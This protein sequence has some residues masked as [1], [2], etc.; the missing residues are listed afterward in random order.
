MESLRYAQETDASHFEF[1]KT[2]DT[3]GMI[4]AYSPLGPKD[5]VSPETVDGVTVTSIGE[6]AF[7]QKQ[8]TNAVLPK[9]LK[10]IEEE[11]FAGNL[12][13][14]LVIPHGVTHIGKG[15]FVANKLTNLTI[16]ESVAFIKDAAFAGNLLTSLIIPHG[17]TW[18]ED[19]A[20]AFNQLTDVVIGNNVLSIEFEAFARNPLMSIVIGNSVKEIGNYAFLENTLTSITIGEKVEVPRYSVKNGFEK[21]YED[22]KRQAG[23]YTRADTETSEWTWNPSVNVQASAI[24]ALKPP[25]NSFFFEFDETNGT[26]TG[27]DGWYS[28]KDIV[29][30]D[31]IN[32]IAVTDI[33]KGAFM[34]SNLTSVSI[35]NSVTSIEAA[36][37]SLNDRLTQVKIGAN[38]TLAAVSFDLS[39]ASAEGDLTHVYNSNG[40]QAGCYIIIDGKWT[41]Q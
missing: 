30:P 36:A 5:V 19:S 35:P 15:A 18:I 1:I 27:Y 17:V 40:K 14:S 33:G 29:I 21:A 26:I 23:T 24:D 9:S 7:L 22:N 38:V 32:G 12:L 34:H 25:T 28:P 11:A 31:A 13:T 37:F 10:T 8:L 3:T 41:K 20:F 16:P 2:T 6:R 39:E 4:R